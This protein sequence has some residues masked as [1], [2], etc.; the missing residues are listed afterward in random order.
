MKHKGMLRGNYLACGALIV[1][2]GVA[3][4]ASCHRQDSNQSTT[5]LNLD[6]TAS[7]APTRTPFLGIVKMWKGRVGALDR[8]VLII[9]VSPA[10]GT[11][12]SN[13]A[14]KVFRRIE[15]PL[16]DSDLQIVIIKVVLPHDTY[17]KTTSFVLFKGDNGL[18]SQTTD[19]HAIDKIVRAG[20]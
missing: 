18:W 20:L 16:H 9:W 7:P 14:L 8:N 2:I 6:K 5:P 15:P 3:L 17:A 10:P 19:K 12:P 4:L 13:A 11:D 1:L